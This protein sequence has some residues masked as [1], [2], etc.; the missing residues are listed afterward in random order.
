MSDPLT[1][2]FYAVGRE[3]TQVS[4]PNSLEALQGLVGGD[5]ESLHLFDGVCLICNEEGKI[6]NLPPNRLVR[7]DVIVGDFFL[8]TANEDGDYVDLTP[9]QLSAA[10]SFMEATSVA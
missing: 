4:I 7:G 9:E 5:I 1:V 3:A 6:H 8:T 10:L 2:L